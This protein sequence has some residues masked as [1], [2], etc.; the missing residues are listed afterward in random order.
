MSSELLVAIGAGLGGMLGWGLADFFAKKTIDEIGDVV[1]LAWGHVFGTATL[2]IVAV[3]QVVINK[4]SVEVATDYRTLTLLV[5]FG[6]IQAI[7]YLLLYIGFGKGQVSVLN[8]IFASFSGITAILSIV[9]LN[10]TTSGSLAIGLTA[11]FIGI[12]LVSIDFKALKHK[13]RVSFTHIPGFKEVVIATIF[14]AVWTLF[15]DIFLGGSDWLSYT[16][17]MYSFMTIA[18]IIIAI[19]RGINLLKIKSG[20]WV[21]LILIGAFEIVA[22]LAIAWGYST[23]NKTSI[24]AL[25]SGAF[26]LPTVIL[27]RLF[28]KE[29][30]TTN[31]T[32]GGLIIVTGIILLSVL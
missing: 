1:T 21:Y 24:V 6:I 19:V 14:A 7:I 11:I 31:Q 30:I 20:M 16:L 32:V 9:L 17:Y 23:T 25:L 28:L 18:I 3:Y 13:R 8:P 15:W 4:Q 12:L 22:Y 29:K 10:E 5:T 27:A 26:S 2:F